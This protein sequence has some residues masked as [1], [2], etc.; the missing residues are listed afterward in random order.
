ME[1]N[2]IE[3]PTNQTGAEWLERETESFAPR[4]WTVDLLLG[5]TGPLNSRQRIPHPFAIRAS[6]Q[7]RP[8]GE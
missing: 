7:V 2:A 8:A 5:S 1:S 4:Y 3:R 6:R